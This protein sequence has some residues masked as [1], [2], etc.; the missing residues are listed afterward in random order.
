MLTLADIDARI[1]GAMVGAG[2][3]YAA[4]YRRPTG[5][6]VQVD[7]LID[8]NVEPFDAPEVRTVADM[9]RV[10]ILR[11]DLPQVPE[12]GDLIIL[13]SGATYTVQRRDTTDESMWSV[14][15]KA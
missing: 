4:T 15:C 10:R 3:G 5:V 8:Q 1:V 11:A 13:E 2:L 14:L 6:D 7:V 12:R 9:A